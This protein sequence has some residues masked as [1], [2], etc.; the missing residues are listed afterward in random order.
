MSDGDNEG[1]HTETIELRASTERGVPSPK[2]REKSTTS[3]QEEAAKWE[4][5]PH[6][7]INP[8]YPLEKL[9]QLSEIN[10]TRD[11]AVRKKAKYTA[12]YG[13]DI[14]P[15][16]SADADDPPGEDVVREFWDG[17]K[18]TLGPDAMATTSTALLERAMQD[19]EGIGFFGLEVLVQG[20]GTPI[21]LA[22]VPAQTLRRRQETS[23]GWVQI[24]NGETQYFAPF[25]ARYSDEGE[26]Q[27]FID[28]ETGE[29]QPDADGAANEL[30]VL[31]N[32][33]ISSV[34]YG[35]PDD[36]S[37][38]Q[39]IQGDQAAK[40]FNVSFFENDGVPRIAVMVEGGT[41]SDRTREDIRNTF[42]A[43]KGA[44]ES[45]RTAI[46]DVEPTANPMDDL[47]G[48]GSSQNVSIKVEPLTVGVEEDA[49][50]T[51]YRRH[52][53]HE[54]LKVHEVPPAVAG[55]TDSANFAQDSQAQREQF[56]EDVIQPRQ[57]ALA[58]RLYETIHKVGLDVDG[59]TL[60]FKL[61][62]ASNRQKE[63]EIA[64][65]VAQGN[66]ANAITVNE[67]RTEYLDLPPL[68]DDAGD[69]LP[70][71]QLLLTEVGSVPS[72]PRG[73]IQAAVDDAIEEAKREQRAE[74]LGYDVEARSDGGGEG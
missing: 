63:V 49:S 39:T 33:A 56:A 41:V 36:A 71:G 65:T 10:E 69:P 16:D 44:E 46:I 12:G 61:R 8:P 14:V 31:H 52:N 70:M 40:T 62:G 17:G 19:Y 9:A 26:E 21:G 43:S 4:E 18:F 37:A 24:R 45:H 1:E 72:G 68:T 6:D 55:Y 58:M 23:E 32:P 20:D 11:V 53:E 34:Y 47:S 51:E 57:R 22:H 59:W 73:D 42:M 50:F 3:Q 66:S 25:G 48:N 27:Y 28:P 60:E 67:L 38:I 35:L 74:D 54:I 15:A 29:R 2:G 7:T 5:G 64:S 13:F 30:I